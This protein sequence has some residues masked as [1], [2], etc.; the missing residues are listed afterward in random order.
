M[1]GGGQHGGGLLNDGALYEPT[2]DRWS[3]INL[4]NPPEARYRASAVWAGDRLLIWGGEGAASELGSGAQLLF[5]SNGTPTAWRAINR[6]NSPSAR[7]GHSVVWTGTRMIIWGGKRA[8]MLLGDGAI[9]D[10][11]LD[12]WAALPAV[13]SPAA[14]AD[15]AVAWT[16]GEMIVLGGSDL[17]ASLSSGG[18]FSPTNNL[19]RPLSNGGNP[20]ARSGAGMI[21]S[22]AELIVFGGLSNQS[23][24]AQL[25]RVSP[26]PQWFFYRKP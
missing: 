12:T 4:S 18:A 9:Y 23:P 14:R 3:P 17:S 21:W 26:Q 25:Q 8:G 5:D 19:W 16:G 15:H 11:I 1:F 10:P 20:V 7:S 13:N 24:S 2:A 22:G 6:L